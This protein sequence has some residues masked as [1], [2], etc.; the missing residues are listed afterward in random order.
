MPVPAAHPP[1]ERRSLREMAVDRIRTAIFDGTL[2]PGEHLNDQELQSWLGIS[3]TPIREALNDLARVGLIEMAAQRY[4]R[5]ALPDPAQRTEVLQTLGAMLGGVVRVTVPGLGASQIKR[6]T[7]SLDQVI[8]AV[9]DRDAEEHGRLYWAFF[10]EIIAACPNATLVTATKDIIDGLAYRLAATRGDTDMDW[11][12]LD[13]GYHALR[14]ALG[15]GDPIAAELAVESIFR[16]S[17]PLISV[18][19]SPQP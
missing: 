18:S 19:S 8:V 15:G 12:V 7:R 3:R 4:T 2:E 9:T 10:D 6:L 1:V 17:E 13:D 5:V 16:L 11:S 14:T